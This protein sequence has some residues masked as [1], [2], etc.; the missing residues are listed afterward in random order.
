[1][2]GLTRK[3][4]RPLLKTVGGKRHATDEDHEEPTAKRRENSEVPT[5]KEQDEININADP[6]SSDDD[7]RAPPPRSTKSKPIMPA[8]RDVDTEL[9][10]AQKK[11]AKQNISIRTPS[12]GTYQS[13]QELKTANGKVDNKENAPSSSGASASDSP[14]RW[15]MEHVSQ[16]KKNAIGYGSKIKNIHAPMPKKFGRGPAK[17]AVRP[18]G[19]ASQLKGKQP[20]QD[21]ESESDVSMKDEEI[22]DPMSPEDQNLRRVTSKAK[23]S[24]TKDKD[25]ETVP[26]DDDQLSEVLDSISQAPVSEKAEKAAKSARLMKQLS[27]WKENNEP[28]SSQA[29]SSAAQEYLDEVSNYIEHLPQVEEEGSHC[30][31]CN[32]PVE[33]TDYWDFWKGKN[34]TVKNKSAFCH[35]HKKISAQKSYVESGYP[36]INWEALPQRIRKN[37]ATLGQILH[38]QR[39][40]IHRDRYEPLALT[41]K[42]AAVPSKRIDLSEAQQEELDSYALD[43]RAAYPGYYGPHGRRLITENIMDLLKSEIKQCKDGVVQASGIAAFVQ[44][45]MVPEAAVLLIM[46]DC[47]VGREEA[48]GIREETYEMGLLVHEEIED[49]VVRRPEDE[50]DEENEYQIL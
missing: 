3:G 20:S 33:Q 9:K 17:A 27:S 1:M 23:S 30:T 25:A 50:S 12:R 22:E 4:A 49:E 45:V 24:Q 13:S 29:E 18:S 28:P 42:A 6:V 48:E 14:I 39:P 41:G 11:T 21:S 44:A 40:S 15:G 32:Q 8:Y 47:K 16:K 43:E 37:K 34:K 38:N 19:S 31:L 46:E 35:L 26:Y 10:R 5:R 36:D 2:A 7:I